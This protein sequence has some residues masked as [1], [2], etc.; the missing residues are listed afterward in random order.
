MASPELDIVVRHMRRVAEM[1]VTSGAHPLHKRALLDLYFAATPEIL[2][3]EADVRPVLVGEL[4]CEW[5]IPKGCQQD[6]RILYIHGGSWMAG[7]S[8]SHRGLTSRIAALTG[9]PVLAINYRLA[10]EF[11]YPAGLEDAIHSLQ[12]LRHN[13][14]DGESTAR[15]LFVMGDSA[16]GNLTLATLLAVKLGGQALP[17]AAVAFSP[18]TDLNY[19]RPVAVELDDKDPILSAQALPLIVANYLQDQ[20]NL[21][22]PLVSPVYGDLAGLPP[23]LLQV[24]DAEILYDDGC[25]FAQ[26]AKE[27]GSD[28]RLSVWPQMPHVFQGFAPV[29]PEANQALKEVAEFL[30]EFQ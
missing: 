12:W 16:G 29:L 23:V 28:V 21:K 15:R 5:L 19:E 8:A 17:D 18:A 11:P 26:S 27:Q 10:P 20:A 25:R 3:V 6:R 7:S 1:S 4:A 24:G 22:D 9:C 2:S 30:E 13:S 14:P